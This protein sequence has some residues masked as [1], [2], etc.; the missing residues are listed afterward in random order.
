MRLF[1]YGT[2]Q[3]DTGHPHS[4]WLF[5]LVE[6]E[7]A[8]TTRGTLWAIPDPQGWY[9]ALLPGEGTV[10]G[11]A[12]AARA[13]LDA[14]ALARLDVFEAGYCRREIV[15]DGGDIAQAWLWAREL[16]AGAR[17]IP[18]GDYRAWL[19]QTGLPPYRGQ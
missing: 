1:L 4:E 17:P 13:A 19:G 11:Q 9:P 5:T 6:P 16:P 15:L 18:G 3:Q 10:M 12:V 2:L 7:G 14:C 8:A